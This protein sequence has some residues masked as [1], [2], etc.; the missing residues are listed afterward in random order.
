AIM[1]EIVQRDEKS[2]FGF[3]GANLEGEDNKL[4]KRFRVY[5]RILTSYFSEEVFFHY[6]IEEKSA[7]AMVRKKC[8]EDDEYLIEKISTYFSD[9]YSDFD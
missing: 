8:L 7:Y 6:Q 2:S 5:R 1:L 9:H 4:T 3:I